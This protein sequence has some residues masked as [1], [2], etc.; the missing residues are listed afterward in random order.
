MLVYPK[1]IPRN[2]TR[3]PAPLHSAIETSPPGRRGRNRLETPPRPQRRPPRPLCRIGKSGRMPADGL[4]DRMLN[5]TQ[6]KE[7]QQQGIEFGAHTMTHPA[8]SRLEPARS[9]AR[10]ARIQATNRRSSAN[11]STRFRLSLRPTLGL[12]PGSRKTDRPPRFPFRRHDLMG[13]QSH[14][15]Q[16][17]SP[18]PPANRPGRLVKPLRLPNE[19]TFPP[20]RRTPR[21]RYFFACADERRRRRKSKD[22]RSCEAQ[23]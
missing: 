14:R 22:S 9:R 1:E 23:R 17:A 15:Q 4:T 7:M 19:S 20:R 10:T 21:Q 13:N 18:A 5:W 16:S 12:Q 6:V 11:R 2:P 3:H 8:M